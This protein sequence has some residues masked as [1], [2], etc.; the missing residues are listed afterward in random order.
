[1]RPAVAM[2]IALLVRVSFTAVEAVIGHLHATADEPSPMS[3]A[4]VYY[5][6]LDAESRVLMMLMMN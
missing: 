2:G 5:M 4:L 3:E 1:M 6:A